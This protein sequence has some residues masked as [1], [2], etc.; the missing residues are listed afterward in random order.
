[1]LKNFQLTIDYP[2][3]IIYWLKETDAATDDLNQVGLTL[4]SERGNYIVA[5][6]AKK[7]GAPSRQRGNETR[8][9]GCY[10]QSHAGETRRGPQAA[11]GAG[12]KSVH[13]HRQGHGFLKIRH[14]VDVK[15]LLHSESNR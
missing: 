3:Q 9:L 6:V 1:M 4:R 10:L 12:R 8:N 5:A 2:N 13:R 15:G 11:S 14:K 7:N